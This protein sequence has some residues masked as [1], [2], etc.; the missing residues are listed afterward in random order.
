MLLGRVLVD[1][2]LVAQPDLLAALAKQQGIGVEPSEPVAGTVADEWFAEPTAVAQERMK[3][4]APTSHGETA[5]PWR[6]TG[7]RGAWIALAAL[8]WIGSLLAVAAAR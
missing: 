7:A 6:I 8:L 3:R 2:G 1:L 5:T 4:Q